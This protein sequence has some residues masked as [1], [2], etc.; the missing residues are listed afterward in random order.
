M[1][2]INV[3]LDPENMGVYTKMKFIRILD[4]SNGGHFGFMQIRY[5]DR[6]RLQTDRILSC[7]SDIFIRR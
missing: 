3:F 4:Y 6:V 1:I 2:V 5:D 7:I